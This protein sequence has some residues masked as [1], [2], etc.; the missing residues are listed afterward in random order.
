MVPNS[1][2][3]SRSGRFVKYHLPTILFAVAILVVSSIPHL[4]VQPLAGY[5]FDKLA[6][7]I[8]YAVFAALVHRSMS[9]VEPA[10]SPAR[11]FWIS[12]LLMFLMAALDELHQLYIP[13]RSADPFDLIADL[14]GG[15]LVL[16]VLT[17]RQKRQG[18]Q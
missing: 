12:L 3:A 14:L 16:L 2:P 1:I 7:F 13:G 10:I 5:P 18:G 8:E 4:N 9:R 17:R 6:H 15:V 11:G